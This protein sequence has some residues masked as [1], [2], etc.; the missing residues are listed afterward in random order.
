[1]KDKIFNIINWIA[2][3]TFVAGVFHTIWFFDIISLKITLTSLA[4]V[5]FNRT[6]YNILKVISE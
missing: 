1:M 3:L 5:I 6:F 4:L 2:F